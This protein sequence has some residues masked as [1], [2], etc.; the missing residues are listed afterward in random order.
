MEYLKHLDLSIV[1][2]L[3]GR[4]ILNLTEGNNDISVQNDAWARMLI[5]TETAK[6]SMLFLARFC[7]MNEY[8]SPNSFLEHSTKNMPNIIIKYKE[9]YKRITSYAEKILDKLILENKSLD[10]DNEYILAWAPFLG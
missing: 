4:H 8:D 10:K 3:I 1:D 6:L 5:A 9:H 7:L 2:E